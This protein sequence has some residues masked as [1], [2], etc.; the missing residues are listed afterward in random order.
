M[1]PLAHTRTGR[2][3]EWA[4]W[5]ADPGTSYTVGAEDEVMLLDPAGWS[6]TQT[7]ADVMA[8]LSGELGASVQPETH[9]SVVELATGVHDDVGGLVADSHALRSAL[10][11]ELATL[12]LAAA[13]AGTH[14]SA[15]WQ[16]MEVSDVPRYAVIEQTMRMLAHREPTMA[17]H[18]HVGVADAEE[19]VAVLNAF[20]GIMPILIALSANSPFSQ[21][22]DSGFA[23][24]R[25]SLFHAFPRTGIPRRFDGYADYVDALDGLIV[26][27]AVPDPSFVWWDVRLQ[28]RFGTV[29]LRAMD[30]Q[31]TVADTAALVAL[32]QSFARLVIEGERPRAE[33]PPEVID[34]NSFLAARDGAG[35][36]LIDPASRR[37]VPVRELLAQLVDECGSHAAALGCAGELRTTAVLAACNGATRQREHLA[38]ADTHGD[39]LATLAAEFTADPPARRFARSGVARDG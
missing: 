17:L 19:A 25:R 28:P 20:R 15:P 4:L 14:P 23:S 7:S 34:E 10:V 12:G 27:G 39:V 18:V 32:V 31:S 8:R 35:A 21:G 24:V 9:A 29:E 6:L 11:S 36:Q 26:P 1:L 5:R 13:A 30:A 3:P 38:R 37:L 16:D 33:V 22:G 2:L